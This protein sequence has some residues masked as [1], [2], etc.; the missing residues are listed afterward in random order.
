MQIVSER[1]GWT[2]YEYRPPTGRWHSLKLVAT[3]RRRKRSWWLGFNGERLSRTT[4]AGLLAEH[5][6]AILQWVLDELRRLD[7]QR[8]VELPQHTGGNP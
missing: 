2:L 3:G 8:F 5:E 6:P 4:D 7:P 1:P